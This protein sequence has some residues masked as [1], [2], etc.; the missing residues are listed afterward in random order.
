MNFMEE[1]KNDLIE[2]F[3][4]HKI[5]VLQGSVSLDISP[6]KVDGYLCYSDFTFKFSKAIVDAKER[7]EHCEKYGLIINNL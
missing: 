2:L 3:K 5:M 1:F 7:L 6:L 4:K